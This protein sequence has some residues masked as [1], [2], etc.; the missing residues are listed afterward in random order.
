MRE[1]ALEA[2]RSYTDLYNTDD[3]KIKLKIDHTYRVA[4]IAEQIARSNEVNMDDYSVDFCWLLGLLHDIGRF[5]QLTQYGTF[6][7]RD[8]I[9]HAELGA[10]ILFSSASSSA[11]DGD[12][13]GTQPL[14]NTFIDPSCWTDPEDTNIDWNEMASIAEVAIRLHNKL[15]LPKDLDP[16]T[17]MFANILRDADKCDIMR[18]L[19][20]PPYDERN[21]AII[22]GSKDHTMGPAR[23]DVMQC[24]LDH[25]C[26]PK[27]FERT[28]F[29]SLISQCCMCFELCFPES[30]RIVRH[31]GYLDTLM[32]LEVADEEM[33]QQLGTLRF[34]M[35]KV[36][37]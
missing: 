6:I 32:N 24:V 34:E 9:D 21:K 12:V 37:N 30:I 28:D 17:R 27:T 31:Q 23:D 29:E 7:D 26:V 2:F 35:A 16:A 18:V 11:S 33:K 14:I 19:I 10:D 1:K 4:S 25:R 15:V 22:R 36:W 5:E 20:E 13:T 8:S 3:V